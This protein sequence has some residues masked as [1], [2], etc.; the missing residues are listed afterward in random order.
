MKEI[1]RVPVFL[2]HSVVTSGARY[3]GFFLEN[4]KSQL[5]FYTFEFI[6]ALKVTKMKL[7]FVTDLKDVHYQIKMKNGKFYF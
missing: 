5:F 7:C 2:K 1:K 6:A 3:F 4:Y